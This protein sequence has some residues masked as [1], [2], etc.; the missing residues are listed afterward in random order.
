MEMTEIGLP[1][2]FKHVLHTPIG[3][4]EPLQNTMEM[5]ER[6]LQTPIGEPEPP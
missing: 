1:E 2:I 5:S 4:P 3:E 6:L